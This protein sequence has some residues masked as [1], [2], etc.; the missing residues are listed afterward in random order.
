[1]DE[2]PV[3]VSSPT[4][5]V[6]QAIRGADYHSGKANRQFQFDKRSQYFIGAHNAFRRRDARQRRRSFL[7]T[8]LLSVTHLANFRLFLRAFNADGS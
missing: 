8:R 7:R 5:R 3:G 1:M 6:I 2:V 4:L